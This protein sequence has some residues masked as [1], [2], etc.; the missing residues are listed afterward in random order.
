MPLA[1]LLTS[2]FLGSIV[3]LVASIFNID[4]AAVQDPVKLAEMR[5]G[6]MKIV[7]DQS[8]AQV[9]ANKAEA[10][11]PGRTWPTWREM[12]GYTCAA[13][14]A[15]HFVIQQMLSF[16]LNACGHH[17]ELP[18]LHVTELM[19]VMM[20]M[21][22]LGGVETGKHYIDS[23][24]NSPPGEMPNGVAPAPYDPDEYK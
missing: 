17:V 6:V 9:E 7:A 18:V 4:P 14:F 12:V 22:G 19:T 16:T 3:N 20:G 15:Y 13:A 1:G 5:V 11:A 8:I 21:L 10:S 23:K 24:Y 2:T